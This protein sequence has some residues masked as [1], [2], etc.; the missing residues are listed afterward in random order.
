MGTTPMSDGVEV[1]SLETATTTKKKKKKIRNSIFRGSV[2][3]PRMTTQDIANV[4]ES[5]TTEAAD[6]I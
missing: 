3:S 1:M 2:G 5:K 4:I 6:N